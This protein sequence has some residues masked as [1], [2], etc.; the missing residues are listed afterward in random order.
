MEALDPKSSPRVPNHTVKET[1]LKNFWHAVKSIFAKEPA[2]PP[3]PKKDYSNYRTEKIFPQYVFDIQK[4]IPESQHVVYRHH[5]KFENI[6][7]FNQFLRTTKPIHQTVS[8]FHEILKK[9]ASY[10]L[11]RD[12]LGKTSLRIAVEANNEIAVEFFISN[13]RHYID[14]YHELYTQLVLFKA[15]DN[16]NLRMIKLMLQPEFI[17]DGEQFKMTN[18]K[19]RNAVGYAI[20]EYKK[21]P[22]DQKRTAWNIVYVLLPDATINPP[23]FSS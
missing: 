19:G 21:A 23:V 5:E 4:R 22:P 2:P 9:N 1:K 6:D 18:E 8:K 10:L 17:I 20:E 14:I 3:V 15:I 13:L 7:D 12:H 11:Q 16:K